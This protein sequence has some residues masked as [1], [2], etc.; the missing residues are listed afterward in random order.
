MAKSKVTIK[1]LK[2]RLLI[3]LTGS[4][5]VFAGGES[6]SYLKLLQANQARTFFAQSLS[7]CQPYMDEHQ[8]QMFE[9]H[10]A[11]MSGR[12]DYIKIT[13]ELKQI[14]ASNQL[15]LPDFKPW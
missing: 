5:T 8:R 1:G 2:R 3:S 4:L 6:I 10:F 9:S 15:E 11:A 7:I 14:A 12:A 13:D